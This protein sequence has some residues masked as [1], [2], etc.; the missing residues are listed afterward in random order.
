MRAKKELQDE[1][2]RLRAEGKSVPEIQ[3]LL[4]VSKSSVSLWVRGVELQQEQRDSL[5]DRQRKFGDANAGAKANKER[6]GDLR[7]TYQEAGRAIAR[8]M[9]PL[10]LAGCMLYW[11]EGAK[12]KDRV[13]FVNSDPN[14]ILFFMRFL[15]EELDV[16]NEM[17][18]L[19]LHCHTNNPQEIR[20]IEIYWT[21]LL[22]LPNECLT[23]TQ[24]HEPKPRVRTK[25]LKNGI[26]GIRV[27][28][29]E[30]TQQIFGA[31]QEYAKLLAQKSS[32]NET[33]EKRRYETKGFL[34]HFG[35]YK[36]VD[37]H[38][39]GRT[40]AQEN[41]PLHIAGC[42]LYWG[43]G[44]KKG[45]SM[46][47]A[48]TDSKM[49][50]VFIRFLIDELS[51]DDSIIKLRIQSHSSDLNEIARIERYWLDCLS[52]YE[53]ALRRTV[54]K[55]GRD[56]VKHNVYPNGICNIDV[57]RIALAQHILAA[58]QEYGGFENPDWL[59]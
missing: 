30:L 27:N 20:Q 42:M 40:K 3:K 19:H 26:C 23:K 16:T 33:W 5:K 31:I 13:N 59:F 14:M 8:E 37:Y 35:H 9:R 21:N 2:R 47:F 34:P 50:Q 49:H 7:L 1:A 12:A 56:D 10:H 52:L 29:T 43:E 55:K 18:S 36:Y 6:F 22:K 28:S 4:R 25:I 15:R 44:S 46:S 54:I 32:L 53:S 58:I 41:H 38:V 45:N 51:L 57:Y 24:I 17:I 48:N 11:A 39:N